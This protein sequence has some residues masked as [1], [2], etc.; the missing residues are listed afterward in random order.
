MRVFWE[1]ISAGRRVNHT[2]LLVRLW[3]PVYAGGSGA[4]QTM[5]KSLR[6]R[7]GDDVC[8]PRYIFTEPKVDYRMRVRW[9]EAGNGVSSFS[10]VSP[11][12]Q[13]AW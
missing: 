1:Q 12:A 5:V 13:S 4:M 6:D 9:R 3:G 10:L 8:D 7:L 11:S 2:E